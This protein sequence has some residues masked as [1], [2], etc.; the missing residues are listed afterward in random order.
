MP[1]IAVINRKGGSGK[2]TLATHLTAYCS[3]SG[4]PVVL[5]DADPQRSAH[6]WL[7]QRKA[8]ANLGG[9]K[10]LGWHVSPNSVV[11]PPAGFSHVML[12]TPGGLRGFDLAR[13]VVYADAILM[14]VCNSVF[15]RESAKDCYEELRGFPRVAEGK[16]KVACVGMRLDPR[17]K[18]DETLR[19]WA[20]TI[21]L[22][23]LT[24]LRET[25]NYVR[26]AE[27]GLTLFDVPALQNHH[28]L[29]QWQPILEWIT[30]VLAAQKGS[31]ALGQT[32]SQ[33]GGPLAGRLTVMPEPALAAT[34]GPTTR[35]FAGPARTQPP[36]RAAAEARAARW[37]DA[38]SLGRLVPKR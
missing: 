12:D 15:D 7:R 8:H 37:I 20:E 33:P 24:V 10:I 26:C 28:D 29:P 27:A 3:R 22:P 13:L 38:L 23:F 5:G 21:D 31:A 2:T 17:T 25:Q 19:R 6:V 35:A 9:A 18:G 36:A 34:D 4:W 1:V 32:T 14:P 16:C 11:R 30:P